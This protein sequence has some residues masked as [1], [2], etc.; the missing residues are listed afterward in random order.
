M[1]IIHIISDLITL[2]TVDG[3]MLSSGYTQ[4]MEI[5]HRFKKKLI[6]LYEQIFNSNRS[7]SQEKQFS[8]TGMTNVW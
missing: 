5:K 7:R 1:I 2:Y 6:G 4:E 3:F 8:V